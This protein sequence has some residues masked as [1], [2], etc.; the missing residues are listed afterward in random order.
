MRWL[1]HGENRIFEKLPIPFR[2]WKDSSDF[3][4]K[5]AMLEIKHTFLFW[6]FDKRSFLKFS[7]AKSTYSHV[8]K[9][10]VSLTKTE[11]EDLIDQTT[12]SM[13]CL[14]TVCPL[15]KQIDK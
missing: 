12:K 6:S 9:L 2:C 10:L 1:K 14:C 8:V 7:N 15:S 3:G 13:K 4:S 11:N 5:P